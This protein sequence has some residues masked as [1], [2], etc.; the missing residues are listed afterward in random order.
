MNV[1]LPT[2]PEILVFEPDQK[3]HAREWIEHLIHWLTDSSRAG[4]LSVVTH[5]DLVGEL[6]KLA[7]RKGRSRI[8]IIAM[9]PK[10][11]ARCNSRHLA[12][13]GFARWLTM[14]RYLRDTRASHGLFLSIDHLSLPFG[15]GFAS[16]GKRVSGILFRPSLHY[17]PS[18]K[19]YWKDLV[20]DAR[21]DILYR[22]MCRNAAIR[23][24]WTLDPDFPSY[25][26]KHYRGGEKIR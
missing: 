10:E 22:G 14:R 12:V 20:R 15:L 2:G 26:I 6:S 9:T 17:E 8:R 13:S 5:P 16:A 4:F 19:R 11:V 23:T 7:G 18:R 3:G 1:R 24:I 25:A 21:K